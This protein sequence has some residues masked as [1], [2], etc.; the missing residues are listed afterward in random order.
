MEKNIKNVVGN[1]KMEKELKLNQEKEIKIICGKIYRRA[2]SGYTIRQYFSY[3][4]IEKGP[5]P[6][7]DRRWKVLEKY[8]VDNPADLPDEPYCDWEL[9]EE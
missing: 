9:I 8:G 7:W 1:K 4:T 3:N 5:G 2:D 6:G